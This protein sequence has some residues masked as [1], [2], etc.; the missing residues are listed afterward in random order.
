MKLLH[1]SD[2][3]M[4]VKPL[5]NRALASLILAAK[6]LENDKKVVRFNNLA[7]AAKNSIMINEARSE[8][9]S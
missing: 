2:Q 4:I 1:I 8:E 6:V 9:I 3:V 5:I 7:K